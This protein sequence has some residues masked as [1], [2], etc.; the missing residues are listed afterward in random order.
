MDNIPL[1]LSPFLFP[2]SPF[3][4]MLPRL[5]HSRRFQKD[6]GIVDDGQKGLG[7][8]LQ[9]GGDAGDGKDLRVRFSV[10]DDGEVGH[11]HVDDGGQI[12]LCHVESFAFGDN[13][14]PQGFEVGGIVAY[15]F[16]HGTKLADLCQRIA[17]EIHNT[18]RL[19]VI[20][21]E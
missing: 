18:I 17:M 16:F 8:D 19:E 2:L 6:G 5:I 4:L 7:L 9:G 15:A 1:P 20:I 3:P 14:F 11:F 10:F 12:G 13:G 21:D